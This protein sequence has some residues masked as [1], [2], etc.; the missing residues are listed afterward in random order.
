MV[1][2]ERFTD[3]NIEREAYLAK[4]VANNTNL[5]TMQN[6]FNELNQYLSTIESVTSAHP[7]V[8]NESALH[9]ILTG[10][11]VTTEIMSLLDCMI[12]YGDG[13]IEVK[14]TFSDMFVQS[15]PTSKIL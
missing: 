9:R 3:G 8:T 14:F 11:E 12:I 10:D 5:E 1:L 4:K 15:E 7:I 6:R 13:S 2:Y